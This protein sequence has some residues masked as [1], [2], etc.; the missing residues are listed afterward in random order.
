MECPVWPVSSMVVRSKASRVTVSVWGQSPSGRGLKRVATVGWP[1][2]LG[3]ASAG[4]LAATDAT[5]A[6]ACF[7]PA[8][9]R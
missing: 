4:Q 2:G 8:S 5:S 9:S 6:R 3:T 7:A 1:T